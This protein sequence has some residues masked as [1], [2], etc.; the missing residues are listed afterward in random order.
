MGKKGKA[1]AAKVPEKGIYDCDPDPAGER[2]PLSALLRDPGKAWELLRT[3]RLLQIL[4]GVVLA[5]FLLRFLNLGKYS[6]WLDEA[7]TLTFARESLLEIWGTSAAGEFNPPLFYWM[8]HLM[9]SFGESEAVLRFLPALLGSLTLVVMY[10]AAREVL[11]RPSSLIAVTLLAFSP[12]HVFYSQEARAY[13]PMLFFFSLAL[14]FFLRATRRG[15]YGNW[16][17]FG[18]FS[19]LAFWTHFYAFVP[20][21]VL[22]LLAFVFRARVISKNLKEAA[23]PLLA[24]GV[25]FL[26]A[27]PL[28]VTTIQLFSQRTG[29][30]PTFGVQGLELITDTLVWISSG[31]NDIPGYSVFLTIVL[32]AF[33]IVGVAWFASR[34]RALAVLL[35]SGFV[36]PLL[37][38]VVLSYRMPMDPRYLICLQPFLFLGVAASFPALCRRLRIRYLAVAAVLLILLASL[39]LFA[40]YYTTSPKTDWRGFSGYLAGQTSTGDLVVVLPGYILQPLGYYYQN[41]TDGTLLYGVYTTGELENI[42]ASAGSHRIYYVVTLDIWST[43]PT[44]TVV[45]WLETH[46]DMAQAVQYG[47]DLF[48]LPSG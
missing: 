38:S 28:V 40:S 29:G 4:L 24:T 21:G 19:A 7:S 26:V 12:F 27:L 30:G 34:D 3:R 33:F 15:G 13:A 17:A 44:G 8:E 25:F 16:I 1:K 48:L 46:T 42:A 36:L 2:V 18:A 20:V 23:A 6:L 43:D 31:I 47:P 32:L 41:E 14:L 11:D 5:G 45:Q 39:P 9:I 37:V 10:L 35:V 22:I